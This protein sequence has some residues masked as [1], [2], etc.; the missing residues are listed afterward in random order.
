MRR[1]FRF[2]STGRRRHATT[3]I[4]GPLWQWQVTYLLLSPAPDV[5]ISYSH[6]RLDWVKEQVYDPLRQCL[7]GNRVFFD[8]GCLE[9]G[10]S[11]LARLASLITRCR[12]FLAVYCDDYFRSDF[13]QWELQLA[14]VRDPTGARGIIVPVALDEAPLP[15][16]CK[17]IQAQSA[18]QPGF[19][20][21]LLRVLRQSPLN[22]NH[23]AAS[24]LAFRLIILVHEGIGIDQAA[25]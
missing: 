25:C 19:P 1:G 6:K 20:E 9:G 3:R 17:L 14:V 2:D 21:D 23:L 16:Y 10:V 24:L 13:C 15:D 5:F 18:A 7:G 8:L 11:W 4:A 12:V 22:R